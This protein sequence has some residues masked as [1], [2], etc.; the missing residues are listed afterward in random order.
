MS[1][2]D[3]T[4][5][6]QNGELPKHGLQGP[7]P[8]ERPHPEGRRNSQG[9]R[10]DPEVEAEP[11]TRRAVI[12]AL[13]E[14]EPGVLSRVAGLFSRRQFN[15]ESLTVGPTTVEGHARITMVAEESN[16]GIDQ[17]EKQLAK[18]KPVIAV[19]ELDDD[20]VRAELVVLKV[21]GD[22]PDK[23]HAITE[24]YEGETLDAGPRTITVQLTGREQKIDDAI[25]AFR[26]F[27][28]IE[29][30]R[31]GQTALARGDQ[32]TVPGEEPATS[33][34]PTTPANYDD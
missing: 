21:R 10:I 33:G 16:P 8:D 2:E 5:A 19:G 29:I 23:V 13:V 9:I 3:S 15:I 24:M 22:E 18:L 28:I 26:Q 32:P 31:T 27:G 17:I 20:A 6:D 14:N 11:S 4:D 7:E 25:D 34:E 12:S 1:S 30:A